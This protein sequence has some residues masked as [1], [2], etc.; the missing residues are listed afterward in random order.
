MSAATTWLDGNAPDLGIVDADTTRLLERRLAARRRAALLVAPVLV[1]AAVLLAISLWRREGS[2]PGAGPPA[3]IAV[4][5]LASVL[6][7]L[8][9]RRD[10]ERIAAGLP[11]RV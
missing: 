8:L 10:D 5:L 7:H 2:A 4:G 3:G 6:M 11:R 9:G 1:V